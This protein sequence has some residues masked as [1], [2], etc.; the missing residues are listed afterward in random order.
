MGSARHSELFTGL[1]VPLAM[2]RGIAA[3]DRRTVVIGD[4]FWKRWL[5][6]M[7]DAIGRSIVLDGQIYTIVGI[8]PGDHRT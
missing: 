8:L 4:R 6:G 1:K 3:T 2:G 5:A 7:P